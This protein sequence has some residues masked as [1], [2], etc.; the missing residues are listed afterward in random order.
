MICRIWEAMKFDE[1]KI[2]FDMNYDSYMASKFRRYTANQLT[3]A[4]SNNRQNRSPF[5]IN[6]CNVNMETETMRQLT[7]H[8]PNITSPSFPIDIHEKCFTELF[9]RERLVYLT[10]YSPHVLRDH[11]PNDIFVVP[12]VI[13]KGSNGPISLAR[14]KQ[15]DIRTAYFP[16]SHH[17]SWGFGGPKGLPLNII[18][19]IMLDFKNK[20][21]WDTALKHVP[22]RRAGKSRQARHTVNTMVDQIISKENMPPIQFKANG[23]PGPDKQAKIKIM[24]STISDANPFK[25]E[26]MNCGTDAKSNADSERNN[27]DD[28]KTN[29][30]RFTWNMRRVMGVKIVLWK[31]IS[32]TFMNFCWEGV[33]IHC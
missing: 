17:L 18:T 25:L 28:S 30:T 26:S 33:E 23:K 29:E 32:K 15:L 19:N 8:I 9:P 7:Y 16:L 27:D 6:L 13:D 31:R 4:I 12:G 24:K 10:P 2:V 21:D 20:Q 1:S 11:N 3:R 22:L 5:V 14:A